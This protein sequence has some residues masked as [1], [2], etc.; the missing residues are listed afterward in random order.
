MTLARALILAGLI[1]A[2]RAGA[3]EVST[4]DTQAASSP[5]TQRLSVAEAVMI[6]LENNRGL[7]VE[8]FNVDIRRTFE[9]EERAAFLPVAAAGVARAAADS[10]ELSSGGLVTNLGRNATAGN[11][12][13]SAY[14]PTGTRVDIGADTTLRR[15]SEQGPQ[16]DALRARVALTQSLLQGFGSAANLARLREARLDTRMSRYEL[17]GFAEALVGRIEQSYWD[18]YLARERIAIF[19]D[20]LRLAVSQLAETRERIRIGTTAQVELAAAQAEVAS[21]RQQLISARGAQ[22]TAGLRL[23]DLLS[24]RGAD[25]G[26]RAIELTEKPSALDLNLGPVAA[27]VQVA[28]TMR[29]DLNQA[30]L[31]AERNELEVVRT[32]NGML[33][34]LDLF[35]SLG[36]TGY[37]DSFNRSVREVSDGLSDTAVGATFSWPL[38]NGAEQARHARA[39]LSGEQTREALSNLSQAVE[40]DVRSAYVAFATASE[41]VSATAATRQLR[42]ESYRAERGKF[43]VGKS[44]SL[45]VAQ[46]QRD[47]LLTRLGEAQAVAAQRQSLVDLLRLE[48]TLLQRRGISVAGD[49]E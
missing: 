1:A 16:L 30:R 13:L 27:H 41:Q 24:T 5:A 21:R 17:R 3:A 45:L 29:P 42:E 40:L 22:E 9:Q 7:R 28:L 48:G 23:L 31:L 43:G 35:V 44:T 46:A 47:L 11:A 26:E 37:A 8:R 33:P 14:L 6:G 10:V 39:V 12:G 19:E 2:A 32:R 38:G 25:T 36:R 4:A 49:G 15:L 34:K 20:S 18:L